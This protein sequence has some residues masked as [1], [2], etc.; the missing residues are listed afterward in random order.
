MLVNFLR[1]KAVAAEGSARSDSPRCLPFL[2]LAGR[3]VQG[4]ARG[5]R[6]GDG[7]VR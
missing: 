6:T 3:P 1:K 4:G 7:Q 5:D 2:V